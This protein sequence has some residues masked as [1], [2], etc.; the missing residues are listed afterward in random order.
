MATTHIFDKTVQKSQIWLQEVQKGL[1]TTDE[2]RA[3]LA[4]RTVLHSLRNHLQLNEAIQLGAELPMLIRGL[5]FE[6]WDPHARPERERNQKEFLDY[7]RHY[8]INESEDELESILGTVLKVV[9]NKIS[10]G[11]VKDIKQNLPKHILNL[12]PH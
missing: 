4:L 12:W 10:K 7:F 3:Y 5:Y 2:N 8:F 1:G 11:E 6:G 9:E